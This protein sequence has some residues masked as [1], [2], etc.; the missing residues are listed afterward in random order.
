LHVDQQQASDGQRTLVDHVLARAHLH[1]R[2]PAADAHLRPH[3]GDDLDQLLVVDHRA[4][5]R[6]DAHVDAATSGIELPPRGIGLAGSGAPRVS[7][8][9]CVFYNLH[10]PG[11]QNRTRMEAA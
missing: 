4:R 7:Q 8:P 2:H 9:P 1:R 5:A 3:V 10:E 11:S 6:V